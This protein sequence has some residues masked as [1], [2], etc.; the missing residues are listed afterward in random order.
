MPG[1]IV[2][3]KAAY[4]NLS[5][6]TTLML[7]ANPSLSSRTFAVTAPLDHELRSPDLACKAVRLVD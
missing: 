6:M 3:A 1:S 5:S 2:T 4:P 7:K